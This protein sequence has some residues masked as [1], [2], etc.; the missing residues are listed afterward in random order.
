MKK[1]L[2]TFRKISSCFDCRTHLKNKPL[3]AIIKNII[4][5]RAFISMSWNPQTQRQSEAYFGENHAMRANQVNPS[6]QGICRHKI[7]NWSSTSLQGPNIQ[8]IK[9]F[10][11]GAYPWGKI[12]KTVSI[13]PSQQPFFHINN[14]SLANLKIRVLIAVWFAQEKNMIWREYRKSIQHFT[15]LYYFTLPLL[16]PPPKRP[17][18]SST[19]EAA[20]VLQQSSGSCMFMS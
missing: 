6:R 4:L 14:A 1:Q 15:I 19:G 13:F 7:L 18:T 17:L 9:M 16:I 20:V 5:D 12:F 8:G 11:Y 3:K 10:K 2:H